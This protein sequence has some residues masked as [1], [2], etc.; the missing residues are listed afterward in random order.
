MRAKGLEPPHLSILEPKSSASTSSA[1]PAG[2]PVAARS[3]HDG[4]EAQGGWHGS[5]AAQG[6]LSG[7]RDCRDETA[8]LAIAQAKRAAM[9]L[10][11]GLG[12]G[13]AEAGAAGLAVARV[14]DAIEGFEGA[15]TVTARLRCGYGDR[16]LNS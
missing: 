1:T 16:L 3:I 8:G 13:E 11:D 2:P 14:F 15:V 12:D 5:I 4:T 7:N 9:A 10:R 6:S